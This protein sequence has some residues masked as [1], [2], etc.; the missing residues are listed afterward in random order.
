MSDSHGSP[1][2]SIVTSL[3]EE[4][5]VWISRGDQAIVKLKKYTCTPLPFCS[6]CACTHVVFFFYSGKVAK[7][8]VEASSKIQ[9]EP[10]E[11]HR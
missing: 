9:R 4:E 6:E 11:V 7:E 5:K 10:P 8:V 3:M 1:S 2:N